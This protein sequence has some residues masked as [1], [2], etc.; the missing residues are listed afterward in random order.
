MR[1]AVA[2][3]LGEHRRHV[4]RQLAGP[5]QRRVEVL[6]GLQDAVVGHE[7]GG[8]HVGPVVDVPHHPHRLGSTHTYR[9]CQDVI[10]SE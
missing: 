1:A 8:A 5:V 3:S 2:G 7:V 9:T 6:R 10:P 4:V